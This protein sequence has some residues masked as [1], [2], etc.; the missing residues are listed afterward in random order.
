MESMYVHIFN[1][2]PSISFNTVA[3][4]V[5]YLQTSK[6]STQLLSKFIIKTS[7]QCRLGIF[8]DFV[9]HIAGIFVIKGDTLTQPR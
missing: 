2:F 7:L 1:S 6:E 4:L 3:K 8:D 5:F 9:S